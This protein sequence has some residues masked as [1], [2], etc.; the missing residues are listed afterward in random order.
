M[1]FRIGNTVGYIMGTDPIRIVPAM[2]L[3]V[4]TRRDSGKPYYTIRP[5]IGGRTYRA[6]NVAGYN[7]TTADRCTAE[8]QDGSRE[9]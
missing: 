6:R 1:S 8:P 2:I 5:I 9:P 7:L 3:Y 4:G